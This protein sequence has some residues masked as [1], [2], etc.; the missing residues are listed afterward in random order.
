M[1]AKCDVCKKRKLKWTLKPVVVR[2]PTGELAT[3]Q[4]KKGC[5]KCRNNVK[6][7]FGSR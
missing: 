1:I 5:K 2:I 6:A 4:K 3:L 7:Y